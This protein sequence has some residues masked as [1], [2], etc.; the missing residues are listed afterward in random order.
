ME[1]KA[2]GTSCLA[3]SKI[4]IKS[5]AM[6]AALLVKKDTDKPWAPARPVRPMR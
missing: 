6:R 2:D 5:F 4:S 3:I 1:N